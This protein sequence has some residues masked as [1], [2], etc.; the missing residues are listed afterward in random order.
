MGF[1]FMSRLRLGAVTGVALGLCGL[2]TAHAATT[3][4]PASCG[5]NIAANCTSAKSNGAALDLTVFNTAAGGGG[6]TTVSGLSGN[7]YTYGKGYGQ[8]TTPFVTSGTTQYGFYDDYVFT[9]GANQVNTVTSSISLGSA[10]EITNLQ[11][12]LYSLTTE[13]IA[14]LTTTPVSTPIQGWSA[15]ALFSGG[16]VSASVITPVTLGAGTYVLEIRGLASGSLGGSYSGNLNL[17]AVPLPGSAWALLGG[18]GLLGV[19][20]RRRPA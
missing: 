12:R 11:A 5:G 17:T 1:R 3:F 13:G 4:T 19:A 8:Q 14:P 15:L 7:T 10:L 20:A 16:A 9:I 18:L 2:G 6:T